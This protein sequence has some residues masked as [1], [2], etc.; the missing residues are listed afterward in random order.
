MRLLPVVTRGCLLE[1]KKKP[2][3][4]AGFLLNDSELSA[5]RGRLSYAN[6]SMVTNELAAAFASPSAFIAAKIL[7]CSASLID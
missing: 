7:L 2:A 4:R 6:K 5:A 1:G 3:T